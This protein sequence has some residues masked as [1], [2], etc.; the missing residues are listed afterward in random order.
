MIGLKHPVSVDNL[1][2]E[3]N[4]KGLVHRPCSASVELTLIALELPDVKNMRPPIDNVEHHK[5]IKGLLGPKQI[6]IFDVLT[7]GQVHTRK[8]VAPILGYP[9]H[10]H[11]WKVI[12]RMSATSMFTFIQRHRNQAKTQRRGASGPPQKGNQQL[13]SKERIR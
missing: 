13:R 8:E 3:M 6:E 11:R 2:R 12:T 4:K 9:S 5:G 10:L 1:L 7:D